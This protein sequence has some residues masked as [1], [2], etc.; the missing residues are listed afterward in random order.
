MSRIYNTEIQ[1][2]PNFYPLETVRY[3]YTGN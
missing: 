3:W 1:I 2:I